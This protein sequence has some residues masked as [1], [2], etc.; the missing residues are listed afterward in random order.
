MSTAWI[1]HLRDSQSLGR[2]RTQAR[3]ERGGQGGQRNQS[4]IQKLDPCQHPTRQG[5]RSTIHD[6]GGG[7]K[8]LDSES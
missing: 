6:N 1:V 8:G 7:N 5:K 4:V 2:E 3:Q